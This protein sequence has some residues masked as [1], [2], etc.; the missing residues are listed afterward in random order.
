MYM[1]SSIDDVSLVLTIA[2]KYR[3]LVDLHRR[4]RGRDLVVPLE[5]NFDWNMFTVVLNRYRRGKFFHSEEEKR[6]VRNIAQ[7]TVDVKRS[8]CNQT[9]VKLFWVD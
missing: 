3:E 7:W 8:L 2:E 6:A 4:V 9:P 1:R 5:L